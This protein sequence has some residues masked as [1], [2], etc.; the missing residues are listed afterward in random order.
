MRVHRFRPR[1]AT[2]VN[3]AQTPTGKRLTESADK[4]DF[5]RQQWA[6]NK[7]TDAITIYRSVFG[8]EALLRRLEGATRVERELG[9]PDEAN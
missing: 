4:D 5:E 7:L 9:K 8:T 6:A 2:I 1:R 3:L